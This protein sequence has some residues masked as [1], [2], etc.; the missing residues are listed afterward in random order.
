MRVLL[1]QQRQLVEILDLRGFLHKERAVLFGAAAEVDRHRRRRL[2]VQVDADAEIF[3]DGLAHRFQIGDS[4]AHRVHR[5]D[6][7]AL[8]RNEGGFAGGPA[9]FLRLQASSGHIA[10][11]SH[12]RRART[13]GPVTR[14]AADQLPDRLAERLAENVP[15]RDLDSADRRIQNRPAAPARPAIH[16]LPVHLDIGRIVAHQIALVLLDR[17]GD[18]RLLAGDR[19]LAQTRDS[20]VR[21]DLYED[22]IGGVLSAA[23]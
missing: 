18:R 19:A 15:Q 3:A 4:F 9:L 7:V 2:A 20:L 21:V 13:S 14:P 10:A 8:G 22:I 11:V 6:D 1:A 12:R 23:D 17:R 16:R 5:V